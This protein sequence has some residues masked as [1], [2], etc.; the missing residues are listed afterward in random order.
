MSVLK[1]PNRKKKPIQS[2]HMVVYCDPNGDAAPVDGGDVAVLVR[3][4]RSAMAVNRDV[5]RGIGSD[6]GGGCYG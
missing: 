2:H 6:D 4:V 3:G 1:L 5:I